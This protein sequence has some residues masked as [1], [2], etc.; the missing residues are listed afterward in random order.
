MGSCAIY[1]SFPSRRTKNQLREIFENLS[2]QAAYDH[3]HQYSGRWNMLSDV[4]FPTDETFKTFEDAENYLSKEA[5][6]WGPALCV[7]FKSTRWVFKSPPTFGGKTA[8][9]IG[10]LKEILYV[11]YDYS[12][13]TTLHNALPRIVE[14]I[15]ADQLTPDEA[16]TAIRLYKA[17]HMLTYDKSETGIKAREDWKIFNEPLVK[18]LWAQTY[19]PY[20]AWLMGGQ[21][22]D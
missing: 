22:A 12:K 8:K 18:K 17:E 13:C 3:G 20:T 21:A 4:E 15:P 16:A 1:R 2:T 10:L 5:Q 11:K 19:K 6:K 9:E 7:K 14:C